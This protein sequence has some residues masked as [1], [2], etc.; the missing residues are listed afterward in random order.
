MSE[1]TIRR[2]REI[3]AARYRAAEKAEKTEKGGGPIQRTEKTPGFTLSETLRQLLSGSSRTESQIRESRRTLQSGEA[4]LAE[5][6]ENLS[7]MEALA[8]EA[9]G[10]GETDRDALQAQLDRLRQ[11]IDRI[12]RSAAG[13]ADLFLDGD[14]EDGADALLY[15]LLSDAAAGQ[16]LPGWLT[17]GGLTADQILSS[18]GLDKTASGADLMAAIIGSSLDGNSAAGRLAALYLGAV[19]A[20]GGIDGTAS[21]EMALEGL[22]QLMEKVAQGV[23]ADQA[24]AELTGGTF[25]SLSD[26]QSQFT[27]G[28]APGLEAFLTNLLL[29][30]EGD[31]LLDFPAIPPMLAGLEGM[32]LELLMN[33]LSSGESASGEAAAPPVLPEAEAALV[34]AG[35]PDAAPPPEDHALS[36]MD[37]GSVR[38]SGQDLSGV[39]LGDNGVLIVAGQGDVTVEGAGPDGPEILLTGSGTVT[40]RSVSAPL[41]TVDGSGVQLAG[42]GENTLQTVRLRPG[43]VLTLDGGGFLRMGSLE[44]APT[45]LLRLRPGAA[46]EVRRGEDSMGGTRIPVILEGPASLAVQADRVSDPRGRSLDP[47]D[48]IWKAL[49]PGWGAVTAMAV[50][51]RQVRTHLPGGE[52]PA[53]VRLW[54]GKG[55]GSQGHPIHSLAFWGR[56]GAGRAKTRYAYLR[57]NQQTGSFQEINMYPNPFT[58]TGGEADRDWVYE[59]ETQTLRILSSRV[60]AVSGGSGT[61][62]SQTP[63]SGRIALADNI[64]SIELTLGGVVCRTSS[65]RAFSLGRENNVTLLLQSGS[66]SLFESGAGCAGVSLGDGACL[67]IDRDGSPG[68]RGP[69]DGSLTAAGGPGGA[70]IGRDSGAGRDR[71]ARIHIRG[72]VI[73]ALGTGGG[74][75]IGGGKGSPMG[76]IVITGGVIDATGGPGGGAGIGGALA[77]PVGDISIRGGTI[78]A[79]AADQAAAIGAG[80]RGACGDILITGTARILKALGGN[81]GADIGACLFGG[82]GQVL[83]SG[84]ADIGS[85]K[86]WTRTGISLEMGADTATLP[87]FRLSAKSLRLDGL[88]V[89][90]REQARAARRT[91]ELDRRWVS[92]IQD[93]YGAL[94]GQLEQSFSGL[95]GSQPEGPVRDSVSAGALVTDMR[96]SI[97]RES[98]RVIRTHSRRTKECV[99]QLLW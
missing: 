32:N 75:G 71:T 20:G 14:L 9:A 34:P 76:S 28:T 25:T 95:Y 21:M 77:A 96:Q 35:G 41:L 57:W 8:R 12:M 38:V 49:L 13:G 24:V 15:A 55:D 19:I 63:F 17:Q 54:L 42:A 33:L 58:V 84:G 10:E 87:Q 61:D 94:Y 86:P 67:R 36:V 40:L 3:S 37:L 43:A 66:S 2:D 93:A 98:A 83:I 62:A 89:A 27:S 48:V 74:A 59:E 44:A 50:D 30:G 53:L 56:D 31:L 82:C 46:A 45:A 47:V 78:S 70:G 68:G 85:A 60:T 16:D 65:G 79:A 72:G 1:L 5:V 39:S 51:G 6:Q 22:R 69:A 23:P 52:L 88:S 99:W 91:V 4:V 29:T 90:T 7:R 11:E 97:L 73:T 64:G 81:P 26:F 18:L 92:R 80:V